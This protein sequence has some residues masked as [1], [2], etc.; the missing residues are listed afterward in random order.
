[1]VRELVGKHKLESFRH[2]PTSSRDVKL[3]TRKLLKIEFDVYF[4][5]NQRAALVFLSSKHDRV[6]KPCTLFEHGTL[7]HVPIRIF[8][9]FLRLV[10]FP[11]KDVPYRLKV[12]VVPSGHIWL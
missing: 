6:Q 4:V 1:M 8:T 11:G 9:D 12:G 3:L 7:L 10:S 5:I 2:I